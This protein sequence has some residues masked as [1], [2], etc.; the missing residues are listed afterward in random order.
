MIDTDT[1]TT[2]NK[3]I[4]LISQLPLE[5]RQP[6]LKTAF[7]NYFLLFRVVFPFSHHEST[8]SVP[9][10]DDTVQAP[11]RIFWDKS[12]VLQLVSSIGYDSKFDDILSLVVQEIRLDI[13][14]VDDV[15]FEKLANFVSSRSIKVNMV[16]LGTS[17]CCLSFLKSP[18][19]KKFLTSGCKRLL[20]TVTEDVQDTEIDM[21]ELLP[22]LKDVTFLK[23]GIRQLQRL[24]DLDF[25]L[26][27]SRLE[28]L[29]VD[30]EGTLSVDFLNS[31]QQDIQKWMLSK[32][33][34]GK[35]LILEPCIGFPDEP[36]E[37]PK[38]NHYE[39]IYDF[40]DPF[41][42]MVLEYLEKL[43]A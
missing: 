5:I 17:D 6:T 24:F 39:D 31:V 4:E 40:D 21:N 1:D 22:L 9:H 36:F 14:E 29:S 16:D 42:E 11:P 41:E 2:L 12:M 23:L 25:S 20:L 37:A 15:C 8:E 43:S 38:Y 7:L 28:C 33:F 32:S 34:L 10:E 18:V 35:K 3:T 26:Q 13:W 30:V 27:S 19:G